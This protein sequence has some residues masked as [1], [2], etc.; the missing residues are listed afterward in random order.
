M[1]PSFTIVFFLFINVALAFQETFEERLFQQMASY[2]EQ[3]APT[4][5]V[6]FHQPYYVPGDTAYF[7]VRSI[8][9]MGNCVPVRR[10]IVKILLS[11]ATGEIE[12]RQNV[13]M[14]DGAAGNQILI[15]NIA[16]GLY[17]FSASIQSKEKKSPAT[18]VTVPLTIQGPQ[19][20]RTSKTTEKLF[21][22]PEG[23]NLV[24]DVVNN[25]L[26][27]GPPS[28]DGYIVD[29]YETRIT[30]FKLDRH[31]RGLLSFRPEQGESYHIVVD[32]KKTRL[33]GS[34]DGIALT[35]VF[36]E[37]EFPIRVMLQVGKKSNLRGGKFFLIISGKNEIYY[38]ASVEF[39]KSSMVMVRIPVDDLPAGILSA[40]IF[41][42]NGEVMAERFFIVDMQKVKATF[43][44]LQEAYN[45]REKVVAKIKLSS[46]QVTVNHS[47]LSC[48]VINI[49]LL[50][51]E[52]LTGFT[53]SYLPSQFSPDSSRKFINTRL[54]E[55]P[56]RTDFWREVL[57]G[58]RLPY[59]PGYSSY[60][61]LTGTAFDKNGQPVPDSSKIDFFLQR[62]SLYYQ[63]YTIG[64]RFDI[65]MLFIFEGDD[66]VFFNITHPTYHISNP[67]IT[68]RADTVLS[69]SSRLGCP[70]Y[71]RSL[72]LLFFQ[73]VEADYRSGFSSW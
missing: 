53:G 37:G 58:S 33:P 40:A 11:S 72:Q 2:R 48:M 47:S 57:N 29:G 36:P 45:T 49:D 67:T 70:Y 69:A 28:Q 26:V 7:V 20:I 59:N 35:T 17:Q 30:D 6:T 8:C 12:L 22:H 18:F 31:G 41:R 14:T 13:L 42:E 43:H 60:L 61:R 62:N 55:N 39:A 46:D 24:H 3:E 32:N 65:P 64:G 38:R 54:L 66:E 9:Q 52:S 10:Q 5:S 51:Q 4:L 71:K 56:I 16:P 63:G 15:P 44:D 19:L 34:T 21:V 27:V 50:A 68:V 23:G 1:R 73:G 25:I